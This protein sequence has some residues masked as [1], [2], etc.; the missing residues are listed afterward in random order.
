MDA[1]ASDEQAEKAALLVKAIALKE[2]RSL[3]KNKESLENPEK[4]RK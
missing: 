4:E 2:M 1:N 3:E